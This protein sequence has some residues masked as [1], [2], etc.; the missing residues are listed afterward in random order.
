MGC[1]SSRSKGQQHSA[2]EGIAKRQSAKRTPKCS[3]CD[4][5]SAAAAKPKAEG[6]AGD[7][8]GEAKAAARRQ[9]TVGSNSEQH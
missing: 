9:C 6:E 3:D 2:Y 7:G 4:S 5:D 1:R 8:D